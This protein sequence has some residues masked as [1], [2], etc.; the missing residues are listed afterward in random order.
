M[1]INKN[2]YVGIEYTLKN[3]KGEVLDSSEDMGSLEY[4][5]GYGMIVPGLEKAMMGR[6]VG[7]AFSVTIEPAEA[8]GERNDSLVFKVDRKQF[9]PD[10]KIEVGME[11]ETDGHHGGSVRVIKIENDEITIDANHPLAGEVLNFDIKIVSN[12]EATEEEIAAFF[13]HS[14]SCGC[15]DDEDTSACGCSGCSG[16]H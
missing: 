4:V 1:K 16:C 14:C 9:P 8:Y 7:D 5:Q 15:G 11:F 6:D 3:A 10:V 13:A 12:R 2:S